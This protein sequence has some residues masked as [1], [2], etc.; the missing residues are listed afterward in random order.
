[1]GIPCQAGR[2][3]TVTYRLVMFRPIVIP[4]MAGLTVIGAVLV[5]ELFFV[6]DLALVVFIVFWLGALAWNG[7]WFLHRVAFEIGVRDGS[8]L[9]WRTFT[10]R[11]E[12]PLTRVRRVNTP[13]GLIGAGLRRI[14][15]DGAPSP[16]LLASPG[17][18]DVVALIA[19]VK[20]GIAISTRWYDRFAA[21]YARRGMWWR[22]LGGGG[23]S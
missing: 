20:P 6:H 3:E 14:E 2:V 15:V 1:L 22:K 19:R 18:D 17:F 21:R 7:Y 23:G 13:F 12:A 10:A 4:V 16:V 5:R 8:T 9:T 11:R